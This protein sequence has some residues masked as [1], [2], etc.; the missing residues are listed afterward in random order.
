MR[1]IF[2]LGCSLAIQTSL[3]ELS[4][5]SKQ[6]WNSNDVNNW[7]FITDR[8]QK[9]TLTTCSNWTI[10]WYWHQIARRH[11][12]FLFSFHCVR[13]TNFIIIK[14]ASNVDRKN[15]IQIFEIIA[16][17]YLRWRSNSYFFVR[18]HFFHKLK[19]YRNARKRSVVHVRELLNTKI[20]KRAHTQIR[21]DS[22]DWPH[23]NIFNSKLYISIY[24]F[25]WY[26]KLNNQLRYH[27]S[28]CLQKT[29]SI[30][31]HIEIGC[32][33]N[34]IRSTRMHTINICTES[35]MK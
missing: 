26:W 13:I 25:Q 12:I 11:T 2:L 24:N 5:K 15:E 27:R 32:Y 34:I 8:V 30:F 17:Y 31:H 4:K 28:L 1:F 18:S 14:K 29:P 21:I 33:K 3:G 19:L 23:T 16:A 35:K 22:F 7:Q 10:Q 6:K 20:G 9:I